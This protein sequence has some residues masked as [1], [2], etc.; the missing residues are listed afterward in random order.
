PHQEQEPGGCACGDRGCRRCDKPDFSIYWPRPF[1]V[2]Q[3][4]KHPRLSGDTRRP[5][6]QDCFD[7]LRNFRLIEYQRTD[8]GECGDCWGNNRDPYGCLGESRQLVSGVEGVDFRIP[9]EPI[10]RGIP[11][12]QVYPGEMI[13]GMPQQA[14]PLAYPAASESVYPLGAGY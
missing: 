11:A 13:Q 14:L 6:P 4:E 5:R 2:G 9:G 8:N 7:C 1:S 12:A 10:Q 3:N